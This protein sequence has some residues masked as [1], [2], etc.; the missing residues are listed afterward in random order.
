MEKVDC[1]VPCVAKDEN[2]LKACLESLARNLVECGD[3]YVS[4]PDASGRKDYDVGGHRVL[5]RNDFDVLPV[6]NVMKACRFRP[7]WILQQLLKML[8]NETKTQDFFVFDADCVLLR[9]LSLYEGGKRRLFLQPNDRDEAAFHRFIA[10]ASGGELCGWETGRYGHTKFIADHGFFS[11]KWMAE[12]VL[13]Y[14]PN[15]NDFV[16]FTVM[17]TYWR[18]DDVDRAIFISEYEMYGLF[19]DK[20]H[21]GEVER[22]SLRKKQ[23]DRWQDFQEEPQKFT[24]E[25][26]EEEAAKALEEGYDVLKLQTNCPRSPLKYKVPSAP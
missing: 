20:F 2:K 22:T 24:M 10:K 26:V 5:F 13:R 6:Q 3:I 1:F 12:M 7:S 19:A 16:N 4:M 21:G 23:I 25:E 9:P 11:R 8:Q 17:N 14:F 18:S 15:A